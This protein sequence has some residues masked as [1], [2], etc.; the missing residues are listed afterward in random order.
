MRYLLETNALSYAFR[1]EG[2]VTRNTREF[3]QVGGLLVEDWYA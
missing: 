3:G 1:G 2:E